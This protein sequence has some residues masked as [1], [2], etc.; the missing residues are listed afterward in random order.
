MTGL[1]FWC[2]LWTSGLGSVSFIV[3][4]YLSH[5]CNIT[6]LEIT[7][8]WPIWNMAIMLLLNWNTHQEHG[9]THMWSHSILEEWGK[10]HPVVLPLS[11]IAGN[12]HPTTTGTSKLARCCGPL[13]STPQITLITPGYTVV[14]CSQT[15]GLENKHPLKWFNFWIFLPVISLLVSTRYYYWTLQHWTH[16]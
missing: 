5:H 4:S 14:R 8:Y 15:R 6:E 11:C 1:D 3:E 13:F 12:S 16:F 2:W 9:N 10:G 7:A